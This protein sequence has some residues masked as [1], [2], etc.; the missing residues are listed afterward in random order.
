MEER[1]EVPD[2]AIALN[3]EGGCASTRRPPKELG[4]ESRAFQGHLK[5]Q[6]VI[7]NDG[8]RRPP[9]EGVPESPEV[10][11]TP[12]DERSR[13]PDVADA[14]SKGG[15]GSGRRPPID[16]E[17]EISNASCSFAVF[18]APGQELEKERA[19]E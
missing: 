9:I 10:I 2:V 8:A 13:E 11:S 1:S 16:L 15:H 19:R 12:A 14:I 5:S 7:P 4:L 18:L 6:P 3:S 17:L